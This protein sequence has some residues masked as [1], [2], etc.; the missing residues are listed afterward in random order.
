MTDAGI[1]VSVQKMILDL[2]PDQQH[3]MMILWLN[4]FF[5]HVF[6]GRNISH[7]GVFD[8]SPSEDACAALS[9][10]SKGVQ[11]I[12]GLPHYIVLICF[13]QMFGRIF[14][15]FFF[16]KGFRKL[17][18]RGVLGRLHQETRV[19]LPTIWLGHQSSSGE[20]I[21]SQSADSA[22]SADS[23]ISAQSA[24]S[25][26]ESLSESSLILGISYC[27]LARCLRSSGRRCT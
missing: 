21:N 6:L 27:V 12:H 4:L 8:A 11:A 13:Q 22:D 1:A 15:T 5:E 14:H 23:D 18:Y 26:E 24:E 2:K 25:A 10:E 17:R 7:F 3:F 16:C 9:V 19:T 20:K